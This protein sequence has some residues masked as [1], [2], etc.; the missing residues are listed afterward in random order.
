M[1]R[2]VITRTENTIA[3]VFVAASLDS[4][5]AWLDKMCLESSTKP[6]VKVTRKEGSAH[7]DYWLVRMEVLYT[8][9]TVAS[10]V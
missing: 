7:F 9:H 8:I 2:Y 6:G 4:A 10:E 1:L 5:N 3:P